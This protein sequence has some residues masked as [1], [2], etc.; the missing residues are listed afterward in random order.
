MYGFSDAINLAFCATVYAIEYEHGVR[1]IQILLVAKSWVTPKDTR[2][3]R[4]ELTAA[5][6]FAK[7]QS[8]VVKTLKESDVTLV[9]NWV[10]STA[11]L[12][13]LVDMGQWSVYVANRE[14]RLGN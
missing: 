3:P 2:I 13:W 8:N 7:L 5:L 1:V 4:L 9:R 12:Y 10:D 14:K 6:M 11:L